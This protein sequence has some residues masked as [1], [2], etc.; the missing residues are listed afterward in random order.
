MLTPFVLPLGNGG[1]LMLRGDEQ[2]VA[3]ENLAGLG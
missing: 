2:F 1:G 3:V